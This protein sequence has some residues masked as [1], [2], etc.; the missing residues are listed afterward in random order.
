MNLSASS[1]TQTEITWSTTN[2]N[3]DM[4][5]EL[6]EQHPNLGILII[7]NSP[8]TLGQW[9]ELLHKKPHNLSWMCWSE[10]WSSLVPL[11]N[12]LDGS[13]VS[14][15][16][17]PDSEPR[18]KKVAAVFCSVLVEL[19]EACGKNMGLV[20]LSRYLDHRWYERIAIDAPRT[21]DARWAELNNLVLNSTLLT[22]TQEAIKKTI[23]SWV[24]S[25]LL[26]Q[27]TTATDTAQESLSSQWLMFSILGKRAGDQQLGRFIKC[28]TTA[29][30]SR[31]PSDSWAILVDD[32][33]VDEVLDAMCLS[34]PE[35]KKINLFVNSQKTEGLLTVRSAPQ[36][37]LPQ[38]TNRWRPF[39]LQQREST[40]LPESTANTIVTSSIKRILD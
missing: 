2:H 33:C 31:M 38:A 20:S 23:Q 22:A 36:H 13:V 6:S 7:E 37:N 19:G 3:H 17:F 1:Q 4:L 14:S 27:L 30:L 10:N 26:G 29:R 34:A 8:P 32:C 39:L 24:K 15:L 5:L 21:F 25:P 40:G 16:L 12:C 11:L 35:G 28:I 9:C 18:V